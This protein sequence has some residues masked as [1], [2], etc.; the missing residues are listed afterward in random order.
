MLAGK[1]LADF[2]NLFARK[3]FEK[4]DDIILEYFMAIFKNDWMQF[5]WN[6]I[7]IYIQTW[8]INNSLDETKSMKLKVILL[9]ILNKDNQWAEDLVNTLLLL[10]ILISH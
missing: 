10:T 9:Q 4:N 7:Y 6:R 5:P 8:M 1:P 3:N 2:T